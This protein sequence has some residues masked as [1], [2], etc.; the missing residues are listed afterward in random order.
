MKS[1]KKLSEIV[2]EIEDTGGISDCYLH[3]NYFGGELELNI[4]FNNEAAD[5]ILK[6]SGIREFEA[7]AYWE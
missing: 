7:S 2:K 3:H 5:T 6:K 1:S 4:E